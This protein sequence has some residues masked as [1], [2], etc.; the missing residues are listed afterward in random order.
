MMDLEKYI[1]E[2]REAFDTETPPEGSEDRF[3]S[4][5]E[6]RTGKRLLFRILTMT[7]AAAVRESPAGG[8]A[9]T[10]GLKEG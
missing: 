10:Y 5:L 6:A 8:R 7:A 3:L 4:R 9:E 2:N 1:R